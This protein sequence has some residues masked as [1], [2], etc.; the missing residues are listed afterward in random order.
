[1]RWW[2][3]RPSSRVTSVVLGMLSDYKISECSDFGLRAGH[4]GQAILSILT[5]FIDGMNVCALKSEGSVLDV[6]ALMS[7]ILHTSA[8]G[9]QARRLRGTRE[10]SKARGSPRR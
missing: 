6:V 8:S 2:S 9:L 10:V 7:P 5:A 1:M 3:V 4:G